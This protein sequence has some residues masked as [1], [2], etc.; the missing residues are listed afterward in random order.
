MAN[1]KISQLTANTNPN[2]SEELVYAYNNTNGKMTLN[3]MKTFASSGSQPTLVSWTNIKTINNQSIL[4]P[5]NID[6][7]W[8]GGGWADA[9]YDAIVDASWDWDYTLVSAAIAA[10]K[11]N[12]F[13]KNWS[14]TETAWWDAYTKGSSFLRIIWESKNWVQITM[15]NTMTLANRR[16]IDMRYGSNGVNFYMENISFDIDFSFSNTVI[17]FSFNENAKDNIVIKNCSFSYSWTDGAMFTDGI[18]VYN[19]DF[20]SKTSSPI[21]ICEGEFTGYWCKFSNTSWLNL[22]FNSNNEDVF[23]HDSDINVYGFWNFASTDYHTS[24]YLYNS[25]F[26][27]K[28]SM[29]ELRLNNAINSSVSIHDLSATPT[30]NCAVC[31]DSQINV[32]TYSIWFGGGD[33]RDNQ[34]VYNCDITAGAVTNPVSMSWC[35]ISASTFTVGAQCAVIWNRF[36]SSTSIS[37]NNNNALFIWNTVNWSSTFTITGNYSI[38]VWNQMR[39]RT[40]TDSS[41]WSIKANNIT[42]S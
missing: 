31:R 26:E 33:K 20:V 21:P 35:Y 2:G 42:A 40:I 22:V 17:F 8:W 1:T 7:Q 9:S 28:G 34:W 15:P 37:M 27:V 4:W 10:G 11:F 5:W 19:C 23:I 38:V 3:T 29:W 25:S 24:L 36:S 16:I 18:T 13:V 14:Y 32:S 6:I 39:Q 30:I 41:T 12:I